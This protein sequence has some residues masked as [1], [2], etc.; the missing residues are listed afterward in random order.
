MQEKH[1][2]SSFDKSQQLDKLDYRVNNTESRGADIS[3]SDEQEQ[4]SFVVKFNPPGKPR[5]KVMW[6][7]IK[8]WDTIIFSSLFSLF[9]NCSER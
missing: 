7:D 5:E 3:K 1:N 8:M 4:I 9:N 6:H 2:N